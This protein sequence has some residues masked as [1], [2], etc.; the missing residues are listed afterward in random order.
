MAAEGA[1]RNPELRRVAMRRQVAEA[2]F[3][4]VDAL[5]EHYG[6]SIMT[7]H[8]DLDEL[9]RRGF[10][11][12][13][14]G[15]ATSAPTTTFHGDLEHRMQAQVEAKLA[16]AREVLAS[17][18]EPGQVIALDDSTTSLM[19]ARLLPKRAPLTVVT[20]FLPIIRALAAQPGIE[21][22][23][24]GG[25]YD[26]AYDSFL[27][28]ATADAA[29]DLFPDVLFLS[30]TAVAAGVCYLQSLSTAITRRALI[31]SAARRV[32]LIDH[33]KFDRRAPHRLVAI[34][35]LDRVVV[36]GG[37]APQTVRDLR[38][39]GVHVDVVDDA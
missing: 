35:D 33:T 28:Q 22:V 25:T 4:R 39:R 14:R 3:V 26:A 8:R 21:L 19:L 10:L 23:G 1:R 16:I 2:G 6:V 9:E 27:G 36:D 38:A 29:A 24:L 13:V 11:H 30:T 32:A 34:A 15:G 7:V 20:H 12:K 17:E 18:V 31:A 5:A 37:T